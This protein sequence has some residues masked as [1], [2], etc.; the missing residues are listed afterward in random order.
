MKWLLFF[1]LLFIL[2]MIIVVRYRRQIQTGIYVWQTFRKM[3]Q[4]NK[5]AK[6]QIEKQKN[7]GDVALVKCAKCGTWMPQTNAFNPRSRAYY[8]SAICMESAVKVG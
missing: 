4:A 1:G 2:G 3:R 6:S 8:C 5:P 7:I